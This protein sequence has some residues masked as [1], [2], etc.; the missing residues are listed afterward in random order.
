MELAV[1]TRQ[2]E[3]LSVVYEFIKDTGFPPTIAEMR[4]K[5]G[6][7]SNQSILDLLEKLSQKAFVK[8]SEGNARNVTILPRGYKE[9]GEPS[10]TPFL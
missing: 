5:L 2:K 1:T 4:E 6:V 9:L 7:S 10:L 8:R 3:L